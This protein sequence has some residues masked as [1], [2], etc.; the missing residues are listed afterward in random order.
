MINKNPKSNYNS[1]SFVLNGEDRNFGSSDLYV[2]LIPNSCWFTNVRYCI[3]SSDW[4]K[5]RK[6]VYNRIDYICECCKINCLES[7]IPIEAHERWSYDYTTRTQ[8]LERIIGLCK[9]CHQSTHIG[10]AK[11][12]GKEAEALEHLKKVRNFN[13][14]ELKEHVDI[15]YAIWRERNQYVWALD[16]G[17]ITSNGYEIVKPVETSERKN[18]SNQKINL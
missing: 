2:D 5:I 9:L 11:I 13:F 6:I 18:I 12:N 16:L 15:A 14:E 10:F 17:L 3:K 8:K 4:N 7:K 1:N